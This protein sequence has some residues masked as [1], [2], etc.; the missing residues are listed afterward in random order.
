VSIIADLERLIA[1]APEWR[2]INHVNFDLT[3]AGA[4]VLGFS[5]YFL[6][7]TLRNQSA[8]T[9][10]TADLYDGADASGIVTFPLSIAAASHSHIWFGPEGV[11]LENGLYVNVGAQ[12]VKGSVF[13]RHMRR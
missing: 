2:P 7:W 9:V 8:S 4:L 13:F 11:W 5:C 10:A 1:E 3:G 6:G 12:E